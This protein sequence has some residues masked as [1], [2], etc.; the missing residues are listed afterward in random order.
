[1]FGRAGVGNPLYH[2]TKELHLSP[3]ARLLADLVA[4]GGNDTNVLHTHSLPV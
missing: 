4:V 3:G 1:M 2:W